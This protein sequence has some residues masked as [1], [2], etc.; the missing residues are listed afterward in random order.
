MVNERAQAVAHDAL[1]NPIVA[2]YADATAASEGN[3]WLIKKYLLGNGNQSFSVSYNF[4]AV[5]AKSDDRA[6]AIAVDVSGSFYVGGF[7]D[8]SSEDTDKD[9][10]L[11]KY[12][13]AGAL[14]WSRT[15][16]SMINGP[17]LPST[18]PVPEDDRLLGV[19]VDMSGSVIAVGYETN[20]WTNRKN[21]L[22][23]K[24]DADG[25]LLWTASHAGMT[26][27]DAG[28]S[29]VCTDS[30]GNIIVAGSDMISPSRDT[31]IIKYDPSGTA[32]WND[33]WGSVGVFNDELLSVGVDASGSIF[34][35]GYTRDISDDGLLIKYSPTGVRLWLDTYDGPLGGDDRFTAIAVRW[36][37]LFGAGGF[38]TRSDLGEGTNWLF[39][40]YDS[41]GSEI[42][43]DTY[44]SPANA[45]DAVCALAFDS[46]TRL[47]VAGYETRTDSGQGEDWRVFRYP[48]QFACP[49]VK[50]A[51][52]K[53]YVVPGEEFTVTASVI[54]A[55]EGVFYLVRSALSAV[56]GH[57]SA[58]RISGPTPPVD[59]SVPGFQTSN[60]EWTWRAVAPGTVS[61][62]ATASGG[63][64]AM[65]T[66][67]ST[68]YMQAACGVTVVAPAPVPEAVAGSM[69]K[70]FWLAFMLDDGVPTPEEYSV[71]VTGPVGAS[72]KVETPWVPASVTVVIPA[73]R[74]ARIVVDNSAG[75]FSNGFPEDR[76]V[77]V[78]STADISVY[79]FDCH[80]CIMDVGNN[81]SSDGTLVMP[82]AKWGC[83]YLVMGYGQAGNPRTQMVVLST[84]NGTVVT[85]TPSATVAGHPAGVPFTVNLDAGQAYRLALI[86]GANDLA[87]T[88]VT[89][90]NPV[91]VFGGASKTGVPFD[92]A[93][94]GNHLYEQ[95]LPTKYWGTRFITVPMGGRLLGDTFILMAESNGTGVNISGSVP[96]VLNRGETREMIITTPVEIT[97]DQPLAVAQYSNS[98]IYD[99][100][101]GDPAMTLVPSIDQYVSDAWLP[102]TSST[103]FADN[104]VGVAI[105]SSAVGSVQ[106]DGVGVSATCFTTVGTS[107]Y[108]AGALWVA[109]GR[110][111]VAAAA[112]FGLQAYGFFQSGT[113]ADAY[114][115]TGPLALSPRSRLILEGPASAERWQS[116]NF[117][118]KWMNRE[119]HP[120]DFLIWDSLPA[121]T[122]LVSASNGGT[123]YGGTV[124]WTINGVPAGGTGE[125]T[126]ALRITSS[127][128]SLRQQA[129]GVYVTS[130]APCP[131]E[132]SSPVSVIPV[133]P[134]A[135]APV[136]VYPN[137]FNPGKAVNGTVKFQGIK[138]GG[139]LHIFTISGRLVW[140][141]VAGV[142][143]LEWN[144]KNSGGEKVVPGVYLW[145]AESGLGKER[146]K[147][148]LQ[149]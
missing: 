78:T 109:Q 110:H 115:W 52:S 113:A 104:Y 46:S 107:G 18:Y 49:T 51:T 20:V 88:I 112:P 142:D 44:N 98:S 59:S 14:I 123:L 9:W 148:F 82:T 66:G 129:L 41:G 48:G 94:D 149:R 133:Y 55:G 140:E 143:P 74:T 53:N 67:G 3:N 16:S 64:T 131:V 25:N 135:A 121:G 24:Y 23:R 147:I 86:A 43:G 80:S 38:T 56:S 83:E 36:D 60:F 75:I 106:V 69:G 144:G 136:K 137:P 85:I 91:A 13:S 65:A 6:T 93:A 28:A 92:G 84:Q 101:P 42:C 130:A 95:M 11:L 114:A 89:A 21:L 119:V 87:G 96:F 10:L 26:G 79:G 32:L 127:T 102:A 146:G 37:G 7:I 128:E 63:S 57:T 45:D 145:T 22:V 19:A 1:G 126:F 5:A 34:A 12:T 139:K 58:V 100:K 124:A 125:V 50:L 138:T 77:H 141:G 97:S 81:W 68:V 71:L 15:Y 30:S 76:G 31:L 33:L 40:K 90:T 134:P 8:R 105:A 99:L 103:L 39:G 35:A 27:D 111:H 72:V 118:I 70:D 73:S 61:F 132:L 2:G 4:S 17:A 62:S 54:N 108:S 122:S 29:A 120:A 117:T 47:T 116:F